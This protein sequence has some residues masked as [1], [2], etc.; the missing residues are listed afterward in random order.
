MKSFALS[1]QFGD[2]CFIEPIPVTFFPKPYGFRKDVVHIN[3]LGGFDVDVF[4]FKREET[5]T[6]GRVCQ[7]IV[8]VDRCHKTRQMGIFFNIHVIRS[9]ILDTW[10]GDEV[11]QFVFVS[12]VQCFQLVVDVDEKIFG[13]ECLDVFALRIY[14]SG[15]QIVFQTRRAKQIQKSGFEFALF[16]CKH[17]AGVI[18]ALKIIHCVCYY[19][20][21]PLQEILS[22][23]LGTTYCYAFRQSDNFRCSVF[24]PFR[25]GMKIFLYGIY[26]RTEVALQNGTDILCRS[27][28]SLRSIQ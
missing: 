4:H 13:N 21:K 25:Q 9:A 3:P 23:F 28:N 6:A 2:F 17:Q 5:A 27:S 26:F 20:Y 1:V 15:K 8:T 10:R 12:L 7:E 14:F 19:R 11:F 24:V 22:P 18:A 16:A